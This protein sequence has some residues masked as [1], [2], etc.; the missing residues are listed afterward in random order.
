VWHDSSALFP[1]AG[2]ARLGDELEALFRVNGLPLRFH[3]A[4][5]NEDMQKIPEPRVNAILLPREDARYG[6]PANAMAMALGNRGGRYSIFVFYPGV[7]RTL[8]YGKGDFSPRQLSELSLALARIV[9]HEV[10]H[11]LAPEG[12]HSESGLM[13]G[14]LR[15]ADLLSKA[16]ALD[17]PS[18][19]QAIAAVRGWAHPTPG[20]K[21]PIPAAPLRSIVRPEVQPLWPFVR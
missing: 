11:A 10:V 4:T 9:A 12:G 20:S 5:K 19:E 16:I 3:A 15:R 18:L 17:G 1:S 2:L 14:K 7:L 21:F 13:S 8:G 6:L